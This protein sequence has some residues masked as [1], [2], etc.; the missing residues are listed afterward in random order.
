[1]ID[2][3]VLYLDAQSE[4]PVI[5]GNRVEDA[6]HRIGSEYGW[7]ITYRTRFGEVLTKLNVGVNGDSNTGYRG[8]KY[9]CPHHSCL[10][11]TVLIGTADRR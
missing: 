3:I 6:F 4:R 2:V 9:R 10:T 11:V 8:Q 5:L 1:M 7:H